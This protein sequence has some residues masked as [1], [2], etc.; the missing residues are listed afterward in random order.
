M[1]ITLRREEPSDHRRVEVLT[2]EAFWGMSGPRCDEH[3]LVHRLRT[4]DCF[5]PELDVVAE[6]G[7][8][9]VGHVVYSRARVVGPGGEHPVLTFGP[10]TV[11]P[12]HQSDGIGGALM[13]HTLA[14]AGRLGHRAVVVYGHPDYYPRFGFRPG[15]EFGIT[16]PGGRTFDALMALALV[17]GGLDGVRGEF[18][19]DPVFQLDPDDVAAFD[20]TFPAK[21]PAVPTPLDALDGPAPAVFDALRSH[22]VS[23]LEQV[24]RFSSAEVEGWDGVGPSGA[25]ELR[26]A[27]RERGIRWG[28]PGRPHPTAEDVTPSR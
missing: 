24:Y 25:D 19:E 2:R 14:E 11:H 5:V 3:L 26:H 16:A 23:A 10:L 8:V 18:H 22:G 28:A 21:E 1:T 27:L 17:P 13:K 9:V 6:L 7:G 12:A 20:A 4:A 15:A